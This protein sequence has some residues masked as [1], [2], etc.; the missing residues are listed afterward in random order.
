VPQRQVTRT[1]K[2]PKQSSSF[3]MWGSTRTGAS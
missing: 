2:S 1:R 3:L